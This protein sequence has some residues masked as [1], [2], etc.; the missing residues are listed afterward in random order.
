MIASFKFGGNAITW[1]PCEAWDG[2]GDPLPETTFFIN[3]DTGFYKYVVLDGDSVSSLTSQKQAP[4]P[5]TIH[6]LNSFREPLVP[7]GRWE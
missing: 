6:R 3:L 2:N 1:S 4:L 5:I 7:F